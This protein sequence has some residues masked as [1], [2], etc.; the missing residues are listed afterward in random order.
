ME[1]RGC[2]RLLRFA[3]PLLVLMNGRSSQGMIF[4]PNPTSEGS[5]AM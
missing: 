5:L 1:E 2:V 3:D 4:K